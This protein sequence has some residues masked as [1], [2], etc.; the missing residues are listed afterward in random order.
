[1]K[2]FLFL[3]LI[4]LTGTASAHIEGHPEWDAWLK[5]QIVPDGTHRVCCDKSDAYLLDDEDIRIRNGQYEARINGEWM[6][7]PNTGVDHPGNTVFG[8]TGNPTGGAI[9]WVF[10]G[11]ARCFGEP[12]GT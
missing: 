3:T 11:A 5:S 1:M 10:Q 12:T 9:A 8:M 4:L 6:V 2:A 7:F